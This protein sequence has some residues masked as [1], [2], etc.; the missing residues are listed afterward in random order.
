M[1]TP[2]NTYTPAPPRPHLSNAL[3]AAQ[4]VARL[5]T[6]ALATGCDPFDLS[7]DQGKSLDLASVLE[8]MRQR[9][10]I[11]G[12]LVRPQA[13]ARRDVSAWTITIGV[14]GVQV[15]LAIYLENPA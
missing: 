3:A 12:E 6:F 11:I 4:A 7:I 10:Y 2:I 13:Q 5:Q 9:G 8:A 15:T 1:V 14:R